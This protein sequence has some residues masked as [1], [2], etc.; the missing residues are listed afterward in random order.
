MLDD[1]MLT[2]GIPFGISL[3]AVGG[4]VYWTERFD[5]SPGVIKRANIDG[6]EVETV[7]MTSGSPYAVAFLDEGPVS[8]DA[9]PADEDGDGVVDEEDNCSSSD[10]SETITIHGRDTGVENQLLDGGCTISDRIAECAM[11]SGNHGSFVRCVATLSNSLKK[12]GLI[13]GKE[14]GAIQRSAAKR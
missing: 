7:I 13:T 6:S 14:K 9:D 12:A 2:S 3:D 1:F 8:S 4:K 10:L 5:N 11:A